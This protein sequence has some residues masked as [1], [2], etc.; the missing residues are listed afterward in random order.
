LIFRNFIEVI[1]RPIGGNSQKITEAL[2]NLDEWSF[3]I[4]DLYDATEGM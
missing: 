2:E 3:N 4:F 1:S